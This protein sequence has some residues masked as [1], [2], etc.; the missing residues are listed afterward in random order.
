MMQ[1]H[2][3][4]QND[5]TDPESSLQMALSVL[6]EQEDLFS[7]ILNQ[8]ESTNATTTISSS[9]SSSSR[10]HPPTNPTEF[11]A[12]IVQALS[13][14]RPSSNKTVMPQ[15]NTPWYSWWTEL[16]KIAIL[17]PSLSPFELHSVASEMVWMSDDDNVNDHNHSKLLVATYPSVC[18]L[19][20]IH[21]L[22]Q[23]P[24]PTI[25][26][27]SKRWQSLVCE[28]IRQ[29]QIHWERATAATIHQEDDEDE[30][31]DD[32]NENDN[33]DPMNHNNS[34]QNNTLSLSSQR[35]LVHQLWTQIWCQ[36]VLPAALKVLLALPEDTSKVAI[37]CGFISTT[38]QLVTFW[39]TTTTSSSSNDDDNDGDM[40]RGYL[41]TFYA[42][43][44]R[45]FGANKNLP[46]TSTT[47][48]ENSDEQ[49]MDLWMYPWHKHQAEIARKY[50]TKRS[51]ED[52]DDKEDQWYDD[53]DDDDDNDDDDDDDDE[54]FAT[55]RQDAI[56]W[57]SQAQ[58]HEHVVG[59][60]TSYDDLGLAVLAYY[61]WKDRP[62]VLTP[63]Y[64]WKIW[65]PHVKRLL[66]SFELSGVVLR[67]RMRFRFFEQLL[68]STPPSSIT[69]ESSNTSDTFS[70]GSPLPIFHLLS[71][72][73]LVLRRPD[74]EDLE[75]QA[76]L[77]RQTDQMVLW[78]KTLLYCYQPIDQVDM[79]QRLVQDCP[80]PGL[81]AMFLDTLRPLILNDQK[82]V[83]KLWKYI[84][85]LLETLQKK[86]MPNGTLV[87]IVDLIDHLEIYIGAIAMLQLCVLAKS[88]L[89]QGQTS[90]GETLDWEGQLKDCHQVLTKT[91][92]K[93]ETSS[94]ESLPPSAFRLNLLE[95]SMSEILRFLKETSNGASSGSTKV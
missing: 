44:K 87:E 61:G 88:A 2:D 5:T 90:A 15:A 14:I 69:W 37:Q 93:W 6:A 71:N 89:P 73:M 76:N 78:I 80:Y 35:R 62:Q 19:L 81:Q 48:T 49:L 38:T 68:K 70:P 28:T 55:H 53:D 40:M 74:I 32:E 24:S 57:A 64:A 46:G 75:V 1:P 18:L 85:S 41:E 51:N 52:S 4:A 42:S 47:D 58:R 33:D 26:R 77:K 7:M 63:S 9:S 95:V 45:I 22:Q 60:S 83:G 39:S 16:S 31:D 94:P 36:H 29:F 13:P 67:Q 65:F 11:L 25:T 56:W 3:D 21:A 8:T 92:R 66:L 43:L 82:D 12:W 10:S 50:N 72:R 34:S 54:D 27:R 86:Y 91:L 17:L 59:M 23:A 79:V 30:N 20:C 84:G